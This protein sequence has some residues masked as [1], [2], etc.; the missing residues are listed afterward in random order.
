MRT[1]YFHIGMHKTG[2]TAI[3]AAF[4]GFSNEKIM[5]A[6]FK[7][8]NHSIYFYTAFS[9]QHQSY[10]IWK[11]AG[12][13]FSQIES[14]KTECLDVIRS[15]FSNNMEKDIIFSGEDLSAIPE[16]GILEVMKLSK[17]YFTEIKII[18][19][20]RDPISFMQSNLQTLISKQENPDYIWG[21]M[22][23][24]RFEKFVNLFGRECIIF[25]NYET[26]L[27]QNKNIVDDFSEILSIKLENSN[28][29]RNEGLSTEAISLLFHLNMVCPRIPT[30]KLLLSARNECARFFENEFPGKF[31][32]PF[33]ILED[34]IDNAD[35]EWLSKNSGIKFETKIPQLNQKNLTSDYSDYLKKFSITTHDKLKNYIN[36][37]YEN[38]KNFKFDTYGYV[39]HIYF[40]FFHKEI[41]KSEQNT[42]FSAS[43]YLELN[44]DVKAAGADPYRH[45]LLHGIKEGRK[46]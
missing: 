43:R 40:N 38:E 36:S 9:G 22:Y 39:S 15:V 11:N 45:Y 25:R 44:P 26:A 6:P 20:V 27:L 4:Q 16:S 33:D 32:L 13:N 18:A 37:K 1:A 7:S 17:E 31:R 28:L 19:Y 23:R 42:E 5:Y 29:W 24:E 2:S 3:Q 35:I 21:P 34:H 12:L 10:H 41:V 8:E 14:K 30:N 46:T